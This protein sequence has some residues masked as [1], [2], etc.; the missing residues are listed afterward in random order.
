MVGNLV[1]ANHAHLE[2]Q[3]SYRMDGFRVVV[4]HGVF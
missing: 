1:E 2:F 3:G 4:H